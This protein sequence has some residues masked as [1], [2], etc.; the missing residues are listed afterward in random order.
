MAH[1]ATDADER[2]FPVGSL[3][4]RAIAETRF[5]AQRLFH[6]AKLLFDA[7]RWNTAI[8]VAILACEEAGKFLLFINIPCGAK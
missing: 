7:E 8:A 1:S 4:S 3:E 6:D 2:E 5:N